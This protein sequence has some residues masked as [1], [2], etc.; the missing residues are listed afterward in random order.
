MFVYDILID[1]FFLESIIYLDVYISLKS[2]KS[3]LFG[4][5]FH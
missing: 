1:Q 5:F 3:L 4:G 2:Q